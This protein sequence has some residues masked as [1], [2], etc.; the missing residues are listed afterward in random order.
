MKFRRLLAAAGGIG[1][2]T[3]LN[4]TL[5]S[6]ASELEPALAGEQRT[7][8]WRGFD[9]AYT[10]AGDPDDPDVLL[11]HGIHAA[12]SSHE[13]EQIFDMVAEDHHVVA[14][15]LPGFGRSSRPAVDYTSSLYTAFITD[16]AADVL[17]DRAAC[18]ASSLTGAYATMA[19]REAN[20]FSRLILVCPTAKTS[21]KERRWLRLLL[22]SPVLGTTA[23]NALASKPSIRWFNTRD[24]YYRQ[25]SFTE[26]DVNYEWRTAHQQG[27]RFAPA[28]F[29]GGFLDPDIDLGVELAAVDVP[30]TLVWG[31][32]ALV[33][34]LEEG[35]KLANRA[36]A[37]LVVVDESRLLP[38]AEHPGPFLEVL[39]DELEWAKH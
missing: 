9:I 35:R 1:L 36:N 20:C 22:R 11:L 38:H 28:S 19:Q 16:F 3:A 18:V 34:P 10:E 12:A 33:T 21:S 15:D 30:V 7:Y 24:G 32:E 4:R 27:A 17:D 31:R 14:P 6:R 39:L 2:V 26:S 5:A 13:F 37:R 25:V 8:R 23:F 29:V